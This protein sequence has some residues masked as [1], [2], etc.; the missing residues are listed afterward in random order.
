[1]NVAQII[2]Q[3]NV[4]GV[5]RGVLDI[6]RYFKN[7]AIENIVISGGGRLLA[8]LAKNGITHYRLPIYR[9]SILSLFLIKPLRTIFEKENIDIAHARS[10]VPAWISFFAT[11]CSRTHFVTTCHGIYKSGAWSEVMGWGKYVICPSRSV[12]RHMRQNFGVPE[13]KI[14]VIDRWVDLDKFRFQDYGV[15]KDSNSIIS[16][17]RI[18]PSKGYEYLIEA[19]RKVVRANPYVKLKIVGSPDRSKM[20]YFNHLKTLVTRFALQYNVQFTGFADDVGALLRDARLLVAPSITEESFGRV[21]IEA[22][23]CGVPV[24][25]TRVGGYREI[26][27]ENVDGV[28]VEPKN[29]QEIGDAIS[30]LLGDGAF[31]QTLTVNAR[32]KVDAHYTIEKCL[33]QT[34]QVY[35][36]TLSHQRILVVKLSSLGD[37]IL[38]LPSLKALH[39]HFPDRSITVLTAKKYA[40]LLYGCPYINDVIAVDENYKKISQL[41]AIAR[42]LRRK[43]FD[44]IVDLQNNRPSHLLTFLA[45]PRES[46][47]YSLRA[48]FLLTKRLRFKRADDPLVSQERILKLLGVSLSRRELI[49]WKPEPPAS[50]TL[51]EGTLIGITI[52]ASLRWSSKNWPFNHIVSLIEMIYKNFPSCKVILFGDDAARERANRI[53]NMLYPRPFNMCGKISLQDLPWALSRLTAFVTPDTATLHLAQSLGVA[54]IALFGATDPERHTVRSRNLYIFHKR[55]FCSFCYKPQC[56]LQEKNLCMEK[57]VPQEVFAKIKEILSNG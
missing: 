31:A 16:L 15:R 25:A 20:D 50:W 48:G 49:F 10:R 45:F 38:I 52:S 28:L 21:I 57:I 24:I 18:A 39:E 33:Q 5:E 11:R 40:P 13:E 44:Y 34:A 9:K 47:G 3:M 6:T 46:F 4:G 8:E 23:A 26:I 55:L 14:I 17:G 51:P 19:F 27:Q 29:T 22:F 36:Q 37:L 56:R 41:R 42:I 32:K 43:S 54:T 1:M 53:E 35:R 30:R 7:S 12:A 2:P